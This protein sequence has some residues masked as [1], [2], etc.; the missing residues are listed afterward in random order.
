[1]GGT[2]SNKLDEL[3]KISSSFDPMPKSYRKLAKFILE[4][5]SLL[6]TMSITQLSKK[7]SVDPATVTRFCQYIGFKGYSELRYSL[8]HDIVTPIKENPDIFHEQ[9]DSAI[10]LKR[11]KEF[12]QQ[13][14]GEVIDLLEPK[15]VERA[16]LELVRAQ[17]VHIYAQGGNITSANYF[18]F[19]L[20]QMGISCYV[21]TD[22]GLA[23]PSAGN[24]TE[25][26]VAIGL[27]LSGNAKI[28]V[29]AM[30]AAKK[31]RATTIGIC[32]F[33]ASHLGRLADILFSFN[34]RVHD[35]I[36]Y[37]PL[38]FISDLA[39]IGALQAVLIGKFSKEL[40]E[41]ILDVSAITKFNRYE[42]R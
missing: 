14:V 29:D 8:K 3:C 13:T 41:R 10:I 18:Q 34:S 36:P 4:N 38:A 12:Y 15:K 26:D 32:G 24:L 21:F 30:R 2:T 40:E 31:R 25:K 5:P 42:N 1:M 27:T 23:L 17:K 28:V 37:I 39:V 35:N 16:A 9:E 33:S 22:P 20:W 7:L 6:E 11:V 19:S